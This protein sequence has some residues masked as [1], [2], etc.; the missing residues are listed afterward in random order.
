[1]TTSLSVKLPKPVPFKASYKKWIFNSPDKGRYLLLHIKRLYYKGI[2]RDRCQFAGIILITFPAIANTNITICHDLHL[3]PFAEW[4]NNLTIG[5][6]FTNFSFISYSYSTLGDFILELTVKVDDCPTLVNLCDFYFHFD[7]SEFISDQFNFTVHSNQ[8]RKFSLSHSQFQGIQRMPEQ[9]YVLY[10]L[11]IYGTC[12]TLQED[13]YIQI[14]SPFSNDIKCH[15]RAVYLDRQ[16]K[17]FFDIQPLF[18]P[19]VKLPFN[20]TDPSCKTQK[21]KI[22]RAHV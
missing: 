7:G 18:S 1:M 6:L 16:I 22:G 21:I 14:P 3:V 20:V 9:T 8:Q 10:F 17:T 5:S 19:L 12:L 11:E 15:I 13:L 2:Q 4:N